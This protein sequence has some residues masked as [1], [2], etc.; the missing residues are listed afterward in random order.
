VLSGFCC[1]SKIESVVIEDVTQ[2]TV[3]EASLENSV[4]YRKRCEWS[5]YLE[6]WP[7]VVIVTTRYTSRK[8]RQPSSQ[9]TSY[10]KGTRETG[11]TPQ[12]LALTPPKANP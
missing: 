5:L 8:P 2:K 3:R 11:R 10:F 7:G 12:S 4:A 6:A 9:G 1:T